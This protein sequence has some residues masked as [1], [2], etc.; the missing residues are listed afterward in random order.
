LDTK[1]LTYPPTAI[2]SV[3]MSAFAFLR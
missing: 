3:C 1:S 2:A